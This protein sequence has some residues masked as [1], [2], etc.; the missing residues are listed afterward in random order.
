MNRSVNRSGPGKA[1]VGR[2]PMVRHS[3]RSLRNAILAAAIALALPTT[4]DGQSATTLPRT[5]ARPATGASSRE[6]TVP[7]VSAAL[8]ARRR[9]QIADVR[10]DLGIDVTRRDTA[11]GRVAVT[12]TSKV[13]GD[14]VLDFRGLA[15]DSLVVNGLTKDVSSARWNGAHLVIDSTLI[16]SGQNRVEIGFRSPIAPAGASI[17]RTHD[18][19]DNS[20]YLYTLLVPSDAN[21]LFPCFDQPDLK[22]RVTLTLITPA[23]WNA[24]ANGER[25]TKVTTG[26][27]VLHRFAETKPL[28]TY[29]IAFAAGPW[30][31][32]TRQLPISE[33]SAAVPVSMFTRASRAKEAESDSLIQM[34]AR[35][36]RWLGTWFGVP[37]A[38]DKYEFLLAPAFPFGGME[39]P[40]AVFYNEES[41][42]YRERPT[43]TQLLGRQATTFHEVAHQWFGDYF[44][45]RWFDDLWLKEG[46]ATYMAA[47]M[48]A[49]LTPQANAWKTF[50]LRNKPIAYGTDATAGTT[51]VWQ[52]LGNLDQA[53][54]NYG[55]IV[56]NKAPGILRQLDYLVGDA[57]FKQ[58]VQRFL[59]DHAYGNATWRELLASIGSAAGR[60]LTSWGA[61]WILRPGMPIVEQKLIVRNGKIA[62]LTL[63][64]RP[65]QPSVSGAGPWPIKMQVLL[66]YADG[67]TERLPVEIRTTSLEVTAARDR[68]APAF[69]FANDGD[70]GYALVLPDSASV[71]WLEHHIG[72]VRDDFLRAMLWGSLWDLVREARLAPERFAALALR[73]IPREADEQLSGALVGRLGT[74]LTRYASAAVR[75]SMLPR[76]DAMLLAGAGDTSR[77][78][79]TRKNFLDASIGLARSDSALRRISRWLDGDS[80][81]GLP[82]RAPTRWAIV[83]RLVSRGTGDS[84]VRLAAE[85]RRDSTNEGRRLAFVANAARPVAANKQVMFTRWFADSSLNEEWVTSSLRSF[86]DP[87]HA[88]LTRRFLEPSLDTLPWIQK[89]RRIFFLGSWL[90]AVFGGQASAESLKAIDIWLSSRPSLP[91]DLRQ[92]ILQSRDELER[93]VAIRSRFAPNAVP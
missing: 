90:G 19:T 58:G 7:G 31:V 53:K 73:E 39:H 29:L 2:R 52:E 59:R 9:V 57:A 27:A 37:Y 68:P 85:T 84:E 16:L 33:G 64:Q 81:M 13:P 82:L 42:I 17:I 36:L 35:A 78:Y 86:N 56:Y 65:A 20:D 10:Y 55:P 41:F 6:L 60:D 4:S 23:G 50:Y 67:R 74:A 45:M 75:D 43:T 72:T 66:A 28:S 1:A 51:P 62:S 40:G 18:A 70:Y 8:A 21:L 61:Q 80:A 83:T 3:K 91:A 69:V 24:L 89:N 88:G 26:A 76:V 77:V 44:T 14:V 22:A 38:F 30:K 92:K 25:F 71:T 15:V 63:T 12:F 34:N 79:G 32:E 11:A 93:T 54:S 47:K 5:P 46:F 87:E 48:Q 49:D